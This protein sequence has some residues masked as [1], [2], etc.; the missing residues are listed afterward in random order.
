MVQVNNKL[1]A[2]TLEGPG[3]KPT[4]NSIGQLETIISTVIGVMTIFGVIYFT[5]HIILA[6]FTLI[7]SHGD[8]KELETGKKRLNNN[9]LGL[10]LIII[11]YGFGAL[12]T[13]LLGIDNVFSLTKVLDP[14]NLK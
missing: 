11:A 10:V 5:I 6:G 9:I 7:S 12:I 14:N 13:N 2:Y 8:P 1:L 4:T 3:I